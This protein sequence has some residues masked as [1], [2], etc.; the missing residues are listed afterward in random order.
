MPETEP[1][2]TETELEEFDKHIQNL[3]GSLEDL[4]S[5]LILYVNQIKTTQENV[6]RLKENRVHSGIS[7]EQEQS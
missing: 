4:K 3:R 5:K 1:L 6:N 2:L 7:V